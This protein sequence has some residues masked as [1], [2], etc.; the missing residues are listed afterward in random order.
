MYASRHV[1]C[2]TGSSNSF[3]VQRATAADRWCVAMRG[4]S[5]PRSVWRRSSSVAKMRRVRAW[6]STRRYRISTIGSQTPWTDTIA[7]RE[8]LPRLDNSNS[9]QWR[10]STTE[11]Q[12]PWMKTVTNSVLAA[13]APHPVTLRI[14][15]RHH[16]SALFL[17]H[18]WLI[19]RTLDP[20]SQSESSILN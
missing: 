13:S 1:A 3:R 11:S 16:D 14:L 5:T 7:N 8:V 9:E 6:A 2:L 20:L 12:T 15:L 19:S 4:T 17:L 18:N 10:T